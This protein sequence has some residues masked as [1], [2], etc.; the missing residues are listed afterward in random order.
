MVA[1]R[2]MLKKL[3]KLSLDASE[4]QVLTQYYWGK[5]I[6]RDLIKI[7]LNQIMKTM[8]SNDIHNYSDIKRL[9][10]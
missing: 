6:L 3:L 7:E 2:L 1:G 10:N 8:P 9:K 4:W 5:G